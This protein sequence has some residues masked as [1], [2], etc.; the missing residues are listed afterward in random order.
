MPAFFKPPTM[1]TGAEILRRMQRVNILD[2]AGTIMEQNADAVVELNKKQLLH[3]LNRF[4]EQ[5]SPK[6]SEDPWFKTAEAA[7][8]YAD[9]KKKLFPDMTYDVPNLIITG[10][11]HNSIS[12]AR[13]ANSL[14]FAASA[15]FAS[16]IEAKYQGSALGLTTE[17][18]HTAYTDIV[19]PPLL[20]QVSAITGFKTGK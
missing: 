11:Y 16:S 3:G 7:K 18:K 4:G 9:W 12:M 14:R 8:N 17:S 13:T 1:P 2:M 20:Q 5:L 19:K 6:Y 10:V 15:S